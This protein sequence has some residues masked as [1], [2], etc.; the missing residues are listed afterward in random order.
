MDKILTIMVHDTRTFLKHGG[1][2]V[3]LFALPVV[4]VLF[5]ALANRGGSASDQ[6]QNI[7]KI[8][9]ENHDSGYLGEALIKELEKRKAEIHRGGPDDDMRGVQLQV[10]IPENFTQQLLLLDPTTLEYVN[11]EGTNKSLNESVDIRVQRAAMAL[12]AA[13]V[14]NGAGDV[15]REVDP[16]ALRQDLERDDAV[17][18][19]V[20]YSNNKPPP[21]GFTQALPG[22]LVMFLMMNLLMYGGSSIATE[23]T[24]GVLERIAVFPISRLQLI[25]GKILGRF[26]LGVFKILFFVIL[27]LFIFEIDVLGNPVPMMIALLIYA[28]ACA[29]LGVL[30]GAVVRTPE[31][32]TMLSLIFGLSFAALGGCWWPLE[33]APE[34]MQMIGRLLPTAWAMDALTKTIHLGYGWDKLTLELIVLAGYAIGATVL[35]SIFLRYR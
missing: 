3:S 18:L 27:A 31:R 30:I 7:I 9:V 16:D 4:F 24:S 23:R 19:N 8:S 13:L 17:P 26:T 21:K 28:W 20:S 1:A 29:A 12:T 2:W 14:K 32:V 5:M 25:F 6:R 35:A 22:V 33:I 11:L 34:M 15:D 10:V